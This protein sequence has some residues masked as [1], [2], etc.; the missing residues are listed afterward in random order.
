MASARRV[1][2]CTSPFFAMG[3]YD[4]FFELEMRL[5]RDDFTCRMRLTA[6]KKTD[7]C[8]AWV[9]F[10]LLAVAPAGN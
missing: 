1:C 8:E 2:H 5:Q 4:R 3:A 9:R 10:Y 6:E 7:G